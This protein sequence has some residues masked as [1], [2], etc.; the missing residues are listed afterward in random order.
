MTETWSARLSRMQFVVKIPMGICI[1]DP[2]SDLT[3]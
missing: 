2:L 3:Y 1:L